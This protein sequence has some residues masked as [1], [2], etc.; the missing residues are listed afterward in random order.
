MSASIDP[1]PRDAENASMEARLARIESHVEHLNADVTDLRGAF[2][3]LD[4]KVDD[5]HRRLDAKLDEFY[6]RLDTKI[7]RLDG[8]IDR[9]DGKIDR[10]D[11][12]IDGVDRRLDAKIDSLAAKVDHH[13]LILGGMIVSLGIGMAGL[14]AKGFHWL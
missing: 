4:A 7:G 12:K 8:R 14:M 11:G 1:V 2:V 13:F 9:L 10:L 3:R 5:V 6:H